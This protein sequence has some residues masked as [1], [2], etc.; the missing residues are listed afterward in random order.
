MNLCPTW[1]EKSRS[2]NWELGDLKIFTKTEEKSRDSEKLQSGVLYQLIAWSVHF[3]S[4]TRLTQEKA[5]VV[6]WILVLLL[7]ITELP[8]NSIFRKNGARLHYSPAERGLLNFKMPNLGTEREVSISRPACFSDLSS[9][10]FCMRVP[11]TEKRVASTDRNIS[12][13]ML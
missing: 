2:T 5:N 1:M 13:D 12:T 8:L 3:T 11:V 7:I 10:G 4:M 9:I 6:Y